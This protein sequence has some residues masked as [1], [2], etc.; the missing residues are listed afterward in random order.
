MDIT[1]DDLLFLATEDYFEIE[2]WSVSIGETVF[3]GSVKDAR[4]SEYEINNV[5]S[6]TVFNNVLT[7]NI[8]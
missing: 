7:L 4:D 2:L 1:V 5:C 3:K 8:D 6:W